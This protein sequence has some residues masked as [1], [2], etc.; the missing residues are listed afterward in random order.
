M[1]LALDDYCRRWAVA[2]MVLLML[3]MLMLLMLMLFPGGTVRPP[4]E[5]AGGE[6]GV[7]L[8]QGTRYKVQGT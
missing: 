6:G 8:V 1:K 7:V 2:K 5:A 4:L 3:L